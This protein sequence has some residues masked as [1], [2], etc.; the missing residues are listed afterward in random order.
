MSPERARSGSGRISPV[1]ASYGV[2]AVL[3]GMLGIWAC[4]AD[5]VEDDTPDAGEP[6]SIDY[7]Y[8]SRSC[9]A[10]AKAGTMMGTRSDC[11]RACCQSAGVDCPAPDGGQVVLDSGARPDAGEESGA[12]TRP[13]GTTCCPD[14]YAC[15]VESNG[16][17]CVQ[18]CVTGKSCSSGCCAPATNA[19]GDPIGPYVCKPNDQKTYHCCDGV[20]ST[21]SGNDCC[22][23][24]SN[25]NHF[26]ARPCQNSPQCGAARCVG[27][28]FD[29]IRTTC[30][31][32]TACGP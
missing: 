16:P 32:P 10:Q 3:A 15:N 23:A 13:C 6:A 11:I 24:D 5:A 8:C 25:D 17:Q 9:D 4:G 29:L 14:G 26:C 31:G 20:F 7:A 28:S 19:A 2:L 30:K 18:T 21:C 27:Y 1:R 22:V 12:C